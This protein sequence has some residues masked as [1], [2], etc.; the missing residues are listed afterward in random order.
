MSDFL[1]TVKLFSKVTISFWAPLLLTLNENSSYS[2]SSP[3]LGIVSLFNFSR[4]S[5]CIKISHWDFNLHFPITN[6]GASQVA[7]VVKKICPPLQE[8]WETP[9]QFLGQSGRSLGDRQGNPLQYSCLENPM[10]REAWRATVHRVAKSWTWLKQLSTLAYLMTLS[11]FPS[12]YLDMFLGEVSILQIFGW[13]ISGGSQKSLDS[14]HSK[15]RLGSCVFVFFLIFFG[16][17]PRSRE[18]KH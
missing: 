7:L 15:G 12:A 8:T 5:G 1:R 16:T 6:D 11:I 18:F 13:Q 3:I 10:D 14:W 9:V 4:F 2:K 17:G